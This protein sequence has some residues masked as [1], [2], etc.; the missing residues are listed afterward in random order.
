MRETPDQ[1]FDRLL[2]EYREAMT[3]RWVN[4]SQDAAAHGL[5]AFI[6]QKR[7]VEN[8]RQTLADT[9]AGRAQDDKEYAALYADRERKTLALARVALGLEV[10]M[11]SDASA[12]IADIS[13]SLRKLLHSG[14]EALREAL[15]V[16]P[17]KSETSVSTEK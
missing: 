16:L 4:K 6:S 3:L 14:L 17:E 7:Y 2:K 8:L 9:L 13:P 1:S 15:G 10:L 5:A 12:P 11:A